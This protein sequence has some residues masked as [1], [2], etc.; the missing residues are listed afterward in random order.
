MY[1]LS[2]DTMIWFTADTHFGHKNIIRF[3]DRPFKDIYEHDTKIATYWNDVVSEKDIVYH[4]GDLA[5]FNNRNKNAII[6][7]VNTLN[8]KKYLI[9]GNH[10]RK[11][12]LI[13]DKTQFTVLPPYHELNVK[14]EELGKA[15][16]ILCHYPFERWNK[17]HYGSFHLHG[18]CHGVIK[19]KKSRM[20]VGIDAVGYTPIS[21]NDIKV[22]FTR[23][24]LKNKMK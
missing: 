3:C 9:P 11:I 4:L 19:N 13:K 6:D 14:D 24:L 18:H 2:E 1:N 10:D 21:L 17:A 16:I 8:G 20:D 15:T 5:F 7:L 12:G 23:A 22:R